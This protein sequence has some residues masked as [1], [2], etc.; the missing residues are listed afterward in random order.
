VLYFNM[1]VGCY[2]E[3][4]A[5]KPLSERNCTVGEPFPG[6]GGYGAYYVKVYPR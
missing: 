1:G 3:V 6:I 2:E 5:D 4:L